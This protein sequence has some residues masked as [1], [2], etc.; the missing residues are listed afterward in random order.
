MIKDI[1]NSQQGQIFNSIQSKI[2]SKENEGKFNKF[3][4]KIHFLNKIKKLIKSFGSEKSSNKDN[5]IK[6]KEFIGKD[7]SKSKIELNEEE[8]VILIEGIINN[9]FYKTQKKKDM[10]NLFLSEADEYLIKK[11]KEKKLENTAKILNKLPTKDKEMVSGIL[12]IILDNDEQLKDLNLLN[13]KI[14]IYKYNEKGENIINIIEDFRND[15]TEQLKDDNLVQLT[16]QLITDLLKDYSLDDYNEKIEKLNKSANIISM[17]NIK[18][19]EKIL[20]T[21]NNFAKTENQKET[22]EKLNRL[23]DNLNYMHFYLYNVNRQHLDKNRKISKDRN[24]E[25]FQ[26]LKNSIMSQIFD[27]EESN[28]DLNKN[29]NMNTIALKLSTLNTNNQIIYYQK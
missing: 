23:I 5:I 28:Y 25:D 7:E 19:Q 11:E 15:E 12:A 14:D 29:K 17:I 1:N 27:E 18:D 6:N 3:I 13:K 20:D 8:L 2:D 24:S 22:M 9:L 16:E 26:N 10:S 21:L 4:K